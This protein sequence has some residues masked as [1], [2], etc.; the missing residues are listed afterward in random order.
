ML[1]TECNEGVEV[2]DPR[3]RLIVHLLERLAIA[4]A[5]RV[6]A[7]EEKLYEEERVVRNIMSTFVNDL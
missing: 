2:L 6:K 4:N 7:L 1:G 3:D 5:E